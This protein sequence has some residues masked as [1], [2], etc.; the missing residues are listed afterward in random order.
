M[1]HKQTIIIW[2]PRYDNCFH[3]ESTTA[4]GVPFHA[5]DRSSWRSVGTAIGI[6]NNQRK[7]NN[8][9][10]VFWLSLFLVCHFLF[11]TNWWKCNKIWLTYIDHHFL[12][13]WGEH[14]TNTTATL[15]GFLK[16]K[17]SWHSFHGFNAWNVCFLS[18]VGTCRWWLILAANLPQIRSW[19]RQPARIDSWNV[20]LHQ[21]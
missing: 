10:R 17:L 11:L 16:G 20:L 1:S 3:V 5:T 6:D 4:Y 14:W 18:A 15:K 7:Q 8:S 12:M 13:W 2:I 9:L 21:V 19:P